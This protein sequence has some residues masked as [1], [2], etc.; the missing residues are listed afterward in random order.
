ME[1]P[2]EKYSWWTI[3]F[4]E[5]HGLH[6]TVVRENKGL[7]LSQDEIISKRVRIDVGRGRVLYLIIFI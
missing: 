7:R 3:R 2:V 6:L 4:P 5:D 1:D